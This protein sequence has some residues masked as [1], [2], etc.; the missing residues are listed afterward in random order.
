MSWIF[1]AGIDVQTDGGDS[2]KEQEGL[3]IDYAVMGAKIRA[4]RKEKKMTQNQ[5]ADL[6]GISAAF[7][8]HIERGTR[9]ASVETLVAIAAALQVSIDSL[10]QG[11][12][13]GRDTSKENVDQTQSAELKL[14][15]DETQFVYDGDAQEPQVQ[16]CYM[17]IEKSRMEAL[18][19]LFASVGVAVVEQPQK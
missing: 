17:R 2:V 11:A 7:F 4:A 16:Y 13:R 19:E 12:V 9:I 3:V 14:R 15:S 6:C 18:R 1:S 5:V 8:G 10:V